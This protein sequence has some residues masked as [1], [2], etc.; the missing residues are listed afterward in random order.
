[1]V[2]Q[3][4]IELACKLAMKHHAGQMYGKYSYMLHLEEV[5][6]HVKDIVRKGLFK[7]LGLDRE[8][9]ICL[10]YLHDILEDTDCSIIEVDSVLADDT[11]IK[12]LA[13]LSK[14]I[15]IRSHEEYIAGIKTNRYARIVKIA[16]TW[17][18]LD[19]SW[20]AG[21]TRRIAKYTKQLNML[22]ED[23]K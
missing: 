23:C 14:N 7:C 11:A 10:A 18:N 4:R 8:T 2:T 3:D 20:K 21:N 19:N 1:M 15:E 22:L 13:L 6:G 17:A 12:A 16:D 5:A 9:L